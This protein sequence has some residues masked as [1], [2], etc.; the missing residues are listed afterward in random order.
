M[1]KEYTDYRA[2][3]FQKYQE[4]IKEQTANIKKSLKSESEVKL[5]KLKVTY[6]TELKNLKDA[7]C[8]QVSHN[9]LL[10]KVI[11]KLVRLVNKQE[12]A[13]ITEGDFLNFLEFEDQQ[14]GQTKFNFLDIERLK[15]EK[16]IRLKDGENDKCP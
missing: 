16:L 9:A 2:A 4:V 6:T 13:L 8:S 15:E 12:V 5:G 10:E 3:L 14:Y 11:T 1:K 7:L